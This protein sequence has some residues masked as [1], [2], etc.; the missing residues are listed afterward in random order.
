[1]A[2]NTVASFSISVLSSNSDSNKDYT[3][4]PS[5]VILPVDISAPPPPES[6][7]ERAVSRVDT[8]SGRY[9]VARLAAR[10]D[11]TG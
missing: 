5:A 2:D 3:G 9:G 11:P 6:R 4:R 8:Q 1:M 7:G 10:R